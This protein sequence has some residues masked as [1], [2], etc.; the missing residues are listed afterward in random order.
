MDRQATR[1]TIVAG[2]AGCLAFPAM[3]EP[4]ALNAIGIVS[5]HEHHIELEKEFYQSLS[6]KTGFDFKVNF[7]PLDVVSVNMQDTL[8]M[9]KSGTFDL[10]Q[11]TIGPIARDDPFLEGID[12]IGIAPTLEDIRTVVEAY[13]KPF[14]DRVASKF[15]ARVMTIWPFGPQVFYCKAGVQGLDDFKNLKVRVYTRTMAALM[16]SLGATP[17]TLQFAEVYPALQRGVADCAVTSPTSGN[18]GN[19]PEVAK[20]FFPLGINWSV[21]AHFM[22]LDKWNKLTQEQQK[23]LDAAFKDLEARYWAMT[24]ELTD[25]AT[26]C[27]TGQD[28]CKGYK[29]FDMTAV[30]VSDKDRETLK[31][32]VEEVVLP[33]WKQACNAGYAECSDI[34]NNSVGK[35]T[36]YTIR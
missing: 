21:N 30:E 24:Q 29:K 14:N 13:R 9:A 1:I 36:G 32:A 33:T 10:V 18:T 11:S 3:A 35:A 20:S 28:A 7:N 22:N 34:W 4:I 6:Q 16:Q 15:N 27:N 19:W 23:A 12:L 17:V 26:A 2:L 8:R 25:E 5:T 31:K